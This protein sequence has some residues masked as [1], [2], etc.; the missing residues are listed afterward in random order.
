MVREYEANYC[1][2]YNGKPLFS[3][4]RCTRY[5]YASGTSITCTSCGSK[6]AVKNPLAYYFMSDNDD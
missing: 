4:P 3:C 1:G 6:L 5:T 2:I